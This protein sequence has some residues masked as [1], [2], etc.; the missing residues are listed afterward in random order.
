[1]TY[2]S[3]GVY[4]EEVPS[5]PRPIAAAPSSVVAILGTTRKGPVLEPTRVAGWEEFVRR[6]GPP[7]ARSVTGE[8]AFGF[9]ANG[10]PAAW[11]VRVDPSTPTRWQVSDVGGAP[12]FTVAASSPGAWGNSLTVGVRA[13]TAGAAGAFY[14]AT[15]T[16]PD[17]PVTATGTHTLEVA[18][19]AGLR[20]GDALALVAVP[21]DGA[22]PEPV[23]ATV[24]GLTG[25][26]VSVEA[27][28]AA[29]MTTG[30]V[31]ASAL[32]GGRTSLHL[33]SGKGFHSGDVVVLAHPNGER[34]SV[35]ATDAES[36]DTATTLQLDF[37]PGFV[38]GAAFVQRRHR[39]AATAS[40]S[41]TP[42]GTPTPR[43]NLAFS[44][45]AFE[46]AL[47][48]PI[49]AEMGPSL[50]ARARARLTVADGRTA[51]WA[52]NTFGVV[53]SSAPPTGPVTLEAPVVAVRLGDS[54]L[55]ITDLQASTVTARY[56][57]LPDGAQVT[58]SGPG[59][60]DVVATKSGGTFTLAVAPDPA[61]TFTDAAFTLQA[62]AD[63]GIAVRCAVPPR[64]GDRLGIDSAFAPVTAVEEVGGDVYVLRFAPGTAVGDPTQERFGLFAVESA[65]VVA[66]RFTLTVDVDGAAAETFPGLSLSPDHR[67]WFARDGV[68]NGSSALV[69]VAPRAPGAAPVSLAS[70]PFYVSQDQPGAD[71]AA[72]NDDVRQALTRLE[73]VPEPAMVICPDAMLITDPLLQKGV[74]GQVVTHCENHRRYAVLDA[75]DD[76]DQGVLAWRNTTVASTYASVY[77]PH[78]RIETLDPESTERFTTVPPSGFVAGAMART[79][80]QRGVHQSIG[81]QQVVGVA[82]LSRTYTQRR[83]D[84]LNPAGVNLIRAFPGRGLRVWGGRNA[85][86]DVTWRYVNV[87]RLFNM[88]ETSV[89]RATQWVVFEPNT[90]QTWIRVKVSVENFLDQQ[91]RA[92]ALAGTKPEQAYRVRVG[93]GATMTEAD[94]DVGLI[95]TEVA[96]AASKP[97][98][99]VVFRFSHKR[100]SE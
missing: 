77:A 27:T 49:Q 62:D 76:D 40:V 65:T 33:A 47:A 21:T 50:P 23:E 87:R 22:V 19:T 34:S 36:A 97:A 70:A 60:T 1:M 44:T 63:A 6:F 88:I 3:P 56:G 58:Y 10:G 73:E 7:T 75:P 61:D 55:S 54:G 78:L 92:G 45:L 53:G 8:A 95:I 42:T 100:Q 4:V 25:S 99:F 84:L 91:W 30:S 28:A 15:V 37:A 81:N 38:P 98:E 9:F 64:V 16:G 57:F 86:D 52:S 93:L 46:R 11:V 12:S 18:S 26:T 80:L 2:L 69:R 68:V 24:T 90:A 96:I 94:I 59:A 72:T 17:V 14:R 51:A 41:G 83:Q 74:V 13:D 20:V 82:A 71:R 5:G 43:T 85:T 48:A 89:D 79:D 67:A 35:V 66:Q 29:A 39:Y 32:G 31:I